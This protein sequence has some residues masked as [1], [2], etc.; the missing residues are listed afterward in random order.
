MRTKQELRQYLSAV[1]RQFSAQ[2]RACWSSLVQTGIAGDEAFLNAGTVMAYYPM[3][4]ELDLRGLLAKWLGIKRFVLPVV[5]GDDIR[6]KVYEG[7]DRMRKGRFGILEPDTE[8]WFDDWQSIDC[9][10]V[11][12][13]AFSAAGARMGRGKGYYDRFLPLVPNAVKIGV[14]FPFQLMDEVPVNEEDIF[15]DRVISCRIPE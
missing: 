4:D 1:H 5:V 10:L 6:L 13:V 2:Q 15:M 7:E 12:G 3:P 11:P 9:I 8:E 14:C